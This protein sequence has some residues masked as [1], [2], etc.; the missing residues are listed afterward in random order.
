M[1]TSIRIKNFKSMSDLDIPLSKLTVLSGMNSS[2]KSSIIQSIRILERFNH[3]KKPVL[4]PGS[5]DLRHMARIPSRPVLFTCK[6]MSGT[7]AIESTYMALA[8]EAISGDTSTAASFV[9]GYPI[10]DDVML[11]SEDEAYPNCVYIGAD[12]LGPRNFLPTKNASE[13]IYDLGENCEYVYEF[14]KRFGDSTIAPVVRHPQARGETLNFNI[15]GWLQEISP[16]TNFQIIESE[17]NRRHGILAADFDGHTPTHVGFGLSCVLPIIVAALGI[18]I[19]YSATRFPILLIENP[20]AHLHPQGQTKIAELIALASKNNMQIVIETHS[21]HFIDG[22]RLSVKERQINREDVAIHYFSK[23]EDQ[24][25]T[26]ES[27]ILNENGKLSF[28]PEGFGDQ[29]MLNRARLA[30]K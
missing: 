6:R 13:H 8:S 16:G 15:I 20:E 14:I 18:T 22:I 2:G 12:R 30:R 7:E 21:D 5:G 4:L 26:V 29:T 25:A 1:I 9:G 19:P 23:N 10:V 11:N 27:P 28:W 3:K 24:A 17:S